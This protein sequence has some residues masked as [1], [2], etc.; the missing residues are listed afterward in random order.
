M[1]AIPI[2]CRLSAVAHDCGSL[3]VGLTAVGGVPAFSA[4]G[5]EAG[6]AGMVRVGAVGEVAGRAPLSGPIELGPAPL[7][8]WGGQ[9]SNRAGSRE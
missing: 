7:A 9:R 1:L 2:E 8:P 6:E 5:G 3:L 4:E